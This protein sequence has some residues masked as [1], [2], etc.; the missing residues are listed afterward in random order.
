[1]TECSNKSL[2]LGYDPGGENAHGV[3]AVRIAADGTLE[4][5]PETAVLR[6]AE[7]VGRWVD[8]RR[9]DLIA[10]GIGILLAW[11]RKCGRACD[12]ALRCKY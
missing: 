12:A 8:E 11:S 7:A 9:D 3:A 1:M 5:K 6:D 2:F 4:S 10:L